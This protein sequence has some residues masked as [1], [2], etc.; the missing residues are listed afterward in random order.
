M[1]GEI[2]NAYR[3]VLGKPHGKQPHRRLRT[4]WEDSFKMNLGDV[5]CEDQR[6]ME[7]TQDHVH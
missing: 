7:L 6:C 3:I 1:M 4:G 2:R 5:G